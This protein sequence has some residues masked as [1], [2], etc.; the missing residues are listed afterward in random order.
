MTLRQQT[1]VELEG[2]NLDF[3]DAVLACWKTSGQDATRCFA[4][5]A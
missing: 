1:D 2:L 3:V 4:L 5:G